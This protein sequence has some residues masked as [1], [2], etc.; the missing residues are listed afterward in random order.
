MQ[1]YRRPSETKQEIDE[2][3]EGVEVG[4]SF[5]VGKVRTIHGDIDVSAEI[6]VGIGADEG[7]DG[8]NDEDEGSRDGDSPENFSNIAFKTGNTSTSLL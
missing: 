6:S 8:L 1:K 5:N 7:E 3:P 2:V 4:T